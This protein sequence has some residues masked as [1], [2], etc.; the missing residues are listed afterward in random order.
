MK[1]STAGYIKN[2]KDRIWRR[3]I[4]GT[5]PPRRVRAWLARVAKDEP[6]EIGAAPDWLKE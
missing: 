3:L 5:V 6:E 4:N 2:K 1:Q